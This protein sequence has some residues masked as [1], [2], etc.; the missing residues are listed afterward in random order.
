MH[1]RDILAQNHKPFAGLSGEEIDSVLLS[2]NR[3]RFF[4]NEKL[5]VQGEVADRIGF[6]VS[7]SID[8]RFRSDFRERTIVG[9]LRAGD[10]FGI[11]SFEPNGRSLVSVVGRQPGIAFIQSRDDFF[12]M[13]KRF[14]AMKDYFYK[15]SLER[16][17]RTYEKFDDKESMDELNLFNR[18]YVFEVKKSIEFIDRNFMNTITLDDAANQN[19][20]SRF[21]FSRLFKAKTGLS[22]K[23]YLNQRRIHEAKKLFVI[24]KLNVSE[25]CFK[26]GYNDHSYFCRVFRRLEGFTPSEFRRLCG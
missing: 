8:L 24:E 17:W 6:I 12:R 9:G 7:G 16:V 10:F 1:E 18:K 15:M 19:G 14:P 2:F 11:M 4:S 21:H 5:A 25:T 13:L 22:F 20:M 26:V 3:Y 23:E